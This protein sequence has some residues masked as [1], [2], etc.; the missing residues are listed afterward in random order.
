MMNIAMLG[1]GFI[2]R[3][4]TDALLGNR[5]KDRVVSVYS[6]TNEKG[7]RFADDYGVDYYTTDMEDAINRKDVDVVCI[8]LPN[9]LHEEAVM[10][11]VKHKKAVMCTKPLGR[12]AEEAY[13]M[14]KAVEEAG[15]FNGY[16]EDL[17]YT[18]KFLKSWEVVRNGGI[19]RVLWAKSRE[20]HPG[21]HSDWFW[22][23]EMAG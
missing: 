15:I 8:S 21:P 3:F 22:D 12:N 16:L 7:K 1:T 2:G 23:K 4:Y 19:G 17:V 9:H 13:R 5:S 11:C 18:P 20:T 14:M 6:R 10:L